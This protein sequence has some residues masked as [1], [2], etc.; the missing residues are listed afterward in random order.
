VVLCLI[1]FP[2]PY[3]IAREQS[4]QTPLGNS[5]KDALFYAVVVDL[6][7]NI[8]SEESRFDDVCDPELQG[9]YEDGEDGYVC[10]RLKTHDAN[11]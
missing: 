5:E 1:D 3:R 10:Q 7:L 2:K 4:F 11:L 6:Q 9:F 8:S